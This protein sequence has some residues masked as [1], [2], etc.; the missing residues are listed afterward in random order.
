MAALK[1]GDKIMGMDLDHGGHLSHGMRINISGRLFEVVSYGVRADDERMDM[2]E[3]RALALKEK[4]DMIVAGAS[5]YAREIDFAAFGSIADEVGCPLLADIAHIAGLVAAGVHADPVPHAAYVT[6]TTHKTLR[7]PRSGMV[8]CRS[9]KAKKLDSAV[10]PGIQGGPLE[11][12]VAAKAVAF[13]EALQPAFKDYAAKVVATARALAEKLMA[14]GWRLVSDGTDNHLV[15][16]DLRSRLPELTGKTGST[17]LQQ[18]GIICNMNKIPFDERTPMTTSGI[19]L[20]TPALTTRGVDAEQMHTV[21][22]WIDRVLTSGGEEA[23]LEAV[24][25]EVLEMCRAHPVPN[26]QG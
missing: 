4:P 16:I 7:G 20:G 6:T 25:G 5:A 13:H 19:R 18:A 24:R 10:F 22:D 14:L 8:L 15:L 26:Q 9:D 11:H 21:A 3:I 1:P 23:T 17:W 12:V 2:D